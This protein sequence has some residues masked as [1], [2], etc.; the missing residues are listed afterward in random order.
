[1]GKM[2]WKILLWI[3]ALAILAALM[4]IALRPIETSA[5]RTRE[6]FIGSTE[7]YLDVARNDVRNLTLIHVF[8]RNSDVDA[9]VK[10]DIWDGGGVWIAPSQERL[11]NIASSLSTDSGS[12]VRGYSASGGS[13]TTLIDNSATFLTS[14]AGTGD[15][16]VNDTQN[17]YGIISALSETG[18]TMYD[19]VRDDVTKSGNTEFTNNQ[20]DVYRVII[21]IGSGASA[22]LVEGLDEDWNEAYEIVRLK[23]TGNNATV[24]TYRMINKM[25]VI[26]SGSGANTGVI[27]ATAQTDSTVTA[28]IGT[29][30]GSGANRTQMAIYQVPAGKVGYLKSWYAG[31]NLSGT[32]SDISLLV[33][34]IGQG[35]QVRNYVA[36]YNYS[37][38]EFRP[39]GA[40]VIP[41]RGI[42]KLQ[43]DNDVD[44][45]DVSGG[46][47]LVIERN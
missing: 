3:A 42:V 17:T 29:V 6:S 2:I 44:N 27:S 47:D 8:G 35:F 11:H 22:V 5:Y 24:N 30:S 46:F 26:H 13:T 18:L 25:V 12:L 36:L 45:V 31:I 7:F 19:M 33:K 15:L 4:V 39:I 34:P 14:G 10:E 41:E 23:G 37:P 16:L 20:G 21:S 1:M 28:Q 9:S 40:I 43:A 38:F 32:G